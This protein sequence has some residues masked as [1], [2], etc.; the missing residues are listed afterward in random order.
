[1]AGGD[2]GS[3]DKRCPKVS[4]ARPE[5]ST[6]RMM[7]MAR[8]LICKTSVPAGA[9]LRPFIPAVVS[10]CCAPDAG[11]SNPGV[12]RRPVIGVAASAAIF[13][14]AVCIFVGA[15]LACLSSDSIRFI[16]TDPV[17]MTAFS[18]SKCFSMT[19]LG[20]RNRSSMTDFSIKTHRLYV[21]S[22]YF[23]M[24]CLNRT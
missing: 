16:V 2:D 18:I 22:F 5:V 14:A 15:A 20:I 4:S 11:A 3:W 7:G 12:S 23:V 8:S 13:S 9:R 17:S 24:S 21:F 19:E 1:M 10:S 6:L